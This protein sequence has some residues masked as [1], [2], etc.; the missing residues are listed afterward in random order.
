MINLYIDPSTNDIVIDKRNVKTTQ[1]EAALAQLCE[2][3]LLMLKGDYFLDKTQGI[4]YISKVFVKTSDKSLIDS[5]FKST[6]LNTSGVKSIISYTGKY[7]GLSR[8]YQIEFK[9]N[10]NLGEVSGDT[11]MEV[12]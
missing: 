12:F 10:T 5:F 7:I 8:A 1:G 3:R 4:P 2:N 6:L 9:V 11:T